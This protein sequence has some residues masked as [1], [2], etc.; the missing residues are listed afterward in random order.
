MKSEF[1][2]TLWRLTAVIASSPD[3]WQMAQGQIVPGQIKLWLWHRS[4][5][6]FSEPEHL[7]FPVP[8][9]Q[10]VTRT[11]VAWTNVMFTFVSC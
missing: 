2:L 8:S 7:R 9:D 6:E 11:N 4:V 10:I 1:W 5:L 3:G